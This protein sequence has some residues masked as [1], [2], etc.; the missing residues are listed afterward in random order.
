MYLFFDLHAV[1]NKTR[2]KTLSTKDNS[3]RRTEKVG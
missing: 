3:K 2:V 1:N